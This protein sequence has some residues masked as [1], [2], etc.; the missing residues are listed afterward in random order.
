MQMLM[1]IHICLIPSSDT[2][3]ALLLSEPLNKGAL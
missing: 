3:G 2:E 1:H